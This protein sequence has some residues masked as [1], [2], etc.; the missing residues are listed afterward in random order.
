V[1]FVPLLVAA[2]LSSGGDDVV[3][4]VDE[5]TITRAAIARRV[6]LAARLKMPLS[7]AQAVESLVNDALLSGEARRLGLGDPRAIAAH[8]ERELRAAAVAALVRSIVAT[9]VPDDATL[10]QMFHGTADFVAYDLLA[11]GSEQEARTARQRLDKGAKLEEEAAGAVTS[12]LYPRAA[13]APLTMRA[14]L[15]P[16]AP[17]LFAAAPGAI[18]GPME[19]DKGWMIARVLRKEIGSEADFAARRPELARAFDKQTLD[20]GRSHLVDQLRA[21]ANVKLDEAFLAAANGTPTAAQLQHP[22]ATVAGAP[23]RYADVYPKLAVLG[24]QGGHMARTPVKVQLAMSVVDERLLEAFAVERGFDKAPEVAGQRPDLE[25]NALAGLA[26]G[27]IHSGVKPPTSREI[28]RHYEEN[29]A[30][31]PAPLDE[32][33]ASVE[34]EVRRRKAADAVEAHLAELR[35]KASVAID[36]AAL[37]RRG[38]N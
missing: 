4:R 13:D 19:D 27:R 6:E 38:A 18:V 36:Q 25:R 29:R 15:G 26:L 17:G 16:L 2:L 28:K 33:R 8:V 32:V 14:Q 21:K 20:A 12:R 7:E 22:I 3:A 34:D 30:R 23:V 9:R 5:V 37:A 1:S 24:G 11:Y 31:Y 35:A 10:R